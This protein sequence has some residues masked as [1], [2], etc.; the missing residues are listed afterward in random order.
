MMPAA[1]ATV[2]ALSVHSRDERLPPISLCTAGK[3]VITTNESRAPMKNATDVS[4]SA[5]ADRDLDMR[6]IESTADHLLKPVL[7]RED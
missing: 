4:T 1:T 7:K 3:A 5:H 2:Y 6:A